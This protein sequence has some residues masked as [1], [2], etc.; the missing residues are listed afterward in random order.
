MDE[1]L[2]DPEEPLKARAHR[3]LK[4][5]SVPTQIKT[6]VANTFAEF[7][8]DEPVVL[9]RNEKRRLYR[10]VVRELFDEIVDGRGD[11]F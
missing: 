8:R 6:L 5:K 2:R 11:D 3:Y 7:M 10:T 4:Q 9:T 1:P